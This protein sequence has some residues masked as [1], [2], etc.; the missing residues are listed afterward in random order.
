[1]FT[2]FKQLMLEALKCGYVTEETYYFHLKNLI[3]IEK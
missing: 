2:Y 1:M 3:E